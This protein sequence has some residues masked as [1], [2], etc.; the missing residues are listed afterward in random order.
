[1]NRTG[2][3]YDVGRVLM[4]QSWRPVLDPHEMH[5]ELQIIK[6]DLH[7]D[8]VRIC[9]RDIDRLMTAGEDALQQDLEVWVSPELWD[10]SPDETLDYLVE[11]AGGAEELRRQWPGRVVFSVGSELT[12]FMRGIVEGDNF[13]ER[14]QSPSFWA[15]VRSGEHNAPLDAFLARANDVVRQRFKGGVTYA[16]VPLEAVDWSRFDF[17]AVD[18]YRDA[19]TRDRFGGLLRRFFAHDRPVII[20]ECGCCTYRGAADAGG[21]GWAIVDLDI[22]DLGRRPPRLNG[23]YVRDE[24][25]QARELTD[26]LTIFDDAGVDGSFVFTFVAPLSPYSDDPTYDLDMPSY[27]LVRSYANRLG[28]LAALF[29][30]PPWD[31]GRPGTSYPDM[32][33]E[34]KQSF[35][36]VADF[37]AAHTRLA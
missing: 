35:R 10:G 28:D 25:E 8:A 14:L 26:V 13:Y 2:V 20:A 7:C 16:S 19:Q 5:R 21:M 11:A 29:P 4:G 34:A 31:A 30:S 32:P 36:A 33:W 17:V 6:D 23:E 24:A 18:L 3:C 27:S 22:A 1:M 15:R 9:G 12:L 37:Y